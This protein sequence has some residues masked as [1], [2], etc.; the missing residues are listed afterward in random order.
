MIYDA[1]RNRIVCPTCQEPMR[2]FG[3]RLTPGFEDV[4]E[5]FLC[6]SCGTGVD[7]RLA[8][9]EALV[10]KAALRRRA[11]YARGYLETQGTTSTRPPTDTGGPSGAGS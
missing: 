10:Q 9:A 8:V 5:M 4:P 3:G 1:R 6:V 11:A 7:L 2:P